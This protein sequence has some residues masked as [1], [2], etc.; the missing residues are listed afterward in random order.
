MLQTV[1]PTLRKVL[2]PFVVLAT[3]IAMTVGLGAPKAQAETT[4]ADAVVY[5]IQ[6]GADS[7]AQTLDAVLYT[8]NQIGFMA[9]RILWTESEIGTMADRIVYVTE[10][11]MD[12]S[13]KVIY[14]ATA[15]W[16]VGTQDGGYLYDVVL[17]PVAALPV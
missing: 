9:D 3:A 12:G 10:L 13:I 17:T 2:L 11:S 14:L 15:L 8:E 1:T 16:P 4:S 6:A 5:V 7:Y